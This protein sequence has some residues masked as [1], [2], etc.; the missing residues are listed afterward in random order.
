[1]ADHIW[2]P[3]FLLG[4][5]HQAITLHWCLSDL[6]LWLR[7]IFVDSYRLPF[8]AIQIKLWREPR[9]LQGSNTKA[10]NL[11]LCMPHTTNWLTS[12]T[13]FHLKYCPMRHASH[14]QKDSSRGDRGEVRYYAHL[15][16]FKDTQWNAAD[17]VEEVTGS[18]LLVLSS[19]KLMDHTFFPVIQHSCPSQ[20]TRQININY[21]PGKAETYFLPPC[22]PPTPTVFSSRHSMIHWL[23]KS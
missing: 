2:N 15:S 7:P 21:F 12:S 6:N 5:K 18:T 14:F 1:M 3:N 13:A 16:K 22:S 11:T 10:L 9:N 8:Q 23:I 17:N 19:L 20:W 4:L